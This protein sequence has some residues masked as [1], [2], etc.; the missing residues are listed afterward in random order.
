MRNLL[1]IVASVFLLLG[2]NDTQ[3]Q[4]EVMIISADGNYT[5][6]VLYKSI[7]VLSSKGKLDGNTFSFSGTLNN[8]GIIQVGELKLVIDFYNENHMAF[9]QC[10]H[11]IDK[12]IAA[13]STLIFE[14]ACKGLSKGVVDSYRDFRIVVG[15]Q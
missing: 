6:N 14:G 5:H 3:Q 13:N 8:K 2:C 9:Y 10:M 4:P 7:E 15:K 11:N 1:V 12:P